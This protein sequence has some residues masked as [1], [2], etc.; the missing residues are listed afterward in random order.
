MSILNP[1]LA[2]RREQTGGNSELEATGQPAVRAIF[3][4]KEKADGF[5]V[6]VFLPGVTKA[7]LE[8]T[9][10]GSQLRIRGR[11]SWKQPEGWT[12]IYRESLD[13]PF[14]LVLQHENMLNADMAEAELRDGVLRLALPKAEA[15]KPKKIKVS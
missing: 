8:I 11:R 4:V 2:R 3:R 14:E 7:N 6:T 15:L 1:T 9:A 5:G 10:E 12:Q 13:A